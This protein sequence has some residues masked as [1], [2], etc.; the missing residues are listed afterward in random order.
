[1]TAKHGPQPVLA[2]L[3]GSCCENSP[4]AEVTSCSISPF[5]VKASLGWQ[6]QAG[7]SLH[8]L[9]VLRS[10]FN[11]HAKWIRDRKQ[12]S[13]EESTVGEVG[14]LDI[15]GCI[16]CKS[17]LRVLFVCQLE[18]L[19]LHCKSGLCLS[20]AGWCIPCRCLPGPEPLVALGRWVHLGLLISCPFGFPT[21][22]SCCEPHK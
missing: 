21:T 19:K 1:M 6:V 18:W 12:P 15:W 20:G 16:T 10:L 14:Q 5:T 11:Q 22:W 7:H 4:A 17:C 3:L 13:F 2:P 8:W 9:S